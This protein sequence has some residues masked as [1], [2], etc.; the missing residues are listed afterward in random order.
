MSR[1]LMAVAGAIRRRRRKNRE[2]LKDIPLALSSATMTAN[3]AQDTVVG[4]ILNILPSADI[5]IVDTAGNRFK[6]VGTQIRAGAVAAVAGSY[7]IV[8]SHGNSALGFY[9]SS[10]QITVS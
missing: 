2:K 5:N 3:S 7:T 10:I 1:A 4:N 9:N 6:L 8:L